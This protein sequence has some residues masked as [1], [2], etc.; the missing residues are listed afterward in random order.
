MHYPHLLKPSRGEAFAFYLFGRTQIFLRECFALK[1]ERGRAKHLE[2]K[3]L[4]FGSNLSP[5][6]FAPTASWDLWVKHSRQGEGS[7]Y[8]MQMRT[9]IRLQSQTT[10]N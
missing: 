6:C 10:G 1:F 4:V 2:R 8:F 3:I 5:K 7:L 9:A